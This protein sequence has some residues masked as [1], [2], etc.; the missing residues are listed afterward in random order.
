MFTLVKLGNAR[1]IQLRVAGK[2]FVFAN[3]D[4][5]LMFG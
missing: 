1:V 3:K 2:T 4:A 5:K